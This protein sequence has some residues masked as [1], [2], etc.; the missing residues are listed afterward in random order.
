MN[1]VDNAIR[2]IGEDWDFSDIISEDQSPQVVNFMLVLD[3]LRF[4]F[5][6]ERFLYFH[7]GLSFSMLG[8]AL[9]LAISSSFQFSLGTGAKLRIRDASGASITE[10]IPFPLLLEPHGPLSAGVPKCLW[11]NGS[12]CS[13]ERLAATW[14]MTSNCS[15]DCSSSGSS[16]RLIASLSTDCG[17]IGIVI[18]QVLRVRNSLFDM[19]VSVDCRRLRTW[20]D[21]GVDDLL[22]E[23]TVTA[24]R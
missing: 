1:A 9:F 10:S 20:S 4:S 5:S 16:L 19:R 14:L 3:L 7:L 15:E 17:W 22:I 6:F 13:S 12:R 8:L 18:Q 2:D 21:Q 24:Q 23:A 11:K